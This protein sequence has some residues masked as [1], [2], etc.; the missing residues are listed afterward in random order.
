MIP[1]G[2]CELVELKPVLRG[3]LE[4]LTVYHQQVRVYLPTIVAQRELGA[5]Y[6]VPDTG[7]KPQRARVQVI[8]GQNKLT[9]PGTRIAIG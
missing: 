7:L 2:D 1:V 3:A 9:W 6:G 5:L 8:I 4:A